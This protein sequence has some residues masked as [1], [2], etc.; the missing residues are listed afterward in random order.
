LTL[1]TLAVGTL[2]LSFQWQFTNTSSGGFT[3]LPSQTN[4][5]LVISGITFPSDGSY[6][7]IV[8]NAYGSRTSLVSRVSVG[9]A[10][11]EL[12]NTGVDTN[13]V[14]DTNTLPTNPDPHYA[15]IQSSD[16]SHLGPD[17][18]VWNMFTFPIASF[19]GNFSNPDGKSQ[20]IGTQADSYS[21]PAGQYVYRIKFMLD[22]VDL[23]KPASLSGIWYVNEAG[24]DILIN[25]QSTGNSLPGAASSNGKFSAPFSI[26]SGFV[27]GVNTLDFVTIRPVVPNNG[28]YLESAVRVDMSDPVIQMSGVGTALPPGKP[29]IN[30]HPADQTVHDGSLGGQSMAT[31]SV[32]ALGRPPLSYQWYADG[33][34][35]GG[36]NA[37][38]L[39]FI[40]PIQ[41][42]QGTNF[43]VVISNDSGSITSHVA[44][45]TILPTNRPPVAP[46]YNL[47]TYSNTTLNVN[48]DAL[49]LAAS[50]PDND[51]LTLTFD[52]ATTNGVG[53]VQAG[54]TLSF[55]PA[56]DYLGA[57]QFNYMV[58]DN[59][60]TT[61]SPININVVPLLVPG[62]V[63]AA[64]SGNNIVLSGGVGTPGGP[65]HVLSTT[66]L[67]TPLANWTSAATGAFDGSG[68]FNV[69]LPISATV[70]QTFYII[71]VP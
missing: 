41:G 64:R 66:D 19:N 30:A 68:N 4:N 42:A 16:Y 45:L 3:N 70:P 63:K 15:L 2:P 1:P 38:T 52:A 61:T 46:S 43:S 18:I 36:A 35:V 55:T 58:T 54:A 22:S 37:R 47:T 5:T 53:L 34:Q 7:L 44:V 62:T 17:A 33:S 67:T 32:V 14:V 13:G 8:T 12:F 25:G 28:T 6:R 56:P 40:S 39:Q 48:L 59:I 23:T 27:A 31:F 9:A 10:F 50:D 24:S 26:T 51:P 57:D 65:F 11:S 69:V 49:Y 29:T 20:W 21:S 60:D 71:S